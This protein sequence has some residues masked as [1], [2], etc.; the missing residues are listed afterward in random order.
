MAIGERN[1]PYRAYNFLLEIDG[2]TRAGFHEYA[3]LE[4]GADS[5]GSHEGPEGY[6]ARR[7]PS[8]AKYTNIS[9][10]HGMTADPALWVWYKNGIGGKIERK[11]GSITLLDAARVEKARWKFQ[12]GW[13]AKWT[14]PS[15][16]APGNHV[17]IETLEIAH[18]GLEN[19]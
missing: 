19:V 1:D 5:I 6:T 11:S 9:L 4:G 15:L 12:K 10:K 2:L 3:G 18:E 16:N 13:V 14:G 17:T 7:F 8:L